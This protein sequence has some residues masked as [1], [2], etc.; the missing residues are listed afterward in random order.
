MGLAP[1]IAC[2]VNL[3]LDLPFW[4]QLSARQEALHPFIYP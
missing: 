3:L 4:P 1:L 2:S